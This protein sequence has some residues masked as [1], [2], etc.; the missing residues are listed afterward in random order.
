[1]EYKVT[2][3]IIPSQGA[4]VTR[5]TDIEVVDL[6]GGASDGEK[7]R[8]AEIDDGAEETGQ[9][10]E[11]DVDSATEIGGGTEKGRLRVAEGAVAHACH[12]GYSQARKPK[13]GGLP[14]PVENSSLKNSSHPS[15]VSASTD[16]IANRFRHHQPEHHV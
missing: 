9:A 10:C 2:T 3:C 16:W 13:R 8:S 6:R 7:Q 12:V 1:M 11:C 4:K 14:L 15:E 5:K